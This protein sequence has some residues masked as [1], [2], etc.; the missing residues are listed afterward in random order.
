LWSTNTKNKGLGPWS[1]GYQDAAKL[2]LKDSKSTTFWSAENLKAG[3]SSGNNDM[4]NVTMQNDGTW[5]F[6]AMVNPYGIV[7][8]VLHP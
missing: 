5:S 7:G 1:L 4:K 6:T 2:V 8:N 3:G